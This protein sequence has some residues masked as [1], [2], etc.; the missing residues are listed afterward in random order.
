MNF[1]SRCRRYCISPPR[2]P[3]LIN[4]RGLTA[5]WRKARASF[6]PLT[7][8]LPMTKVRRWPGIQSSPPS[9]IGCTL[10]ASWTSADLREA[11]IAGP[12]LFSFLISGCCAQK[13]RVPQQL[14]SS[15]TTTSS[16]LEWCLNDVVLMPVR[17][18]LQPSDSHMKVRT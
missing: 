17:V 3:T 16:R 9:P 12:L 15:A 13:T 7:P 18:E 4:G 6:S 8:E 10:R 5:S 1:R 14:C 11:S 2:R